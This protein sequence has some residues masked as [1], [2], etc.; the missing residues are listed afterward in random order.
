M[1]KGLQKTFLQKMIYSQ[2][3]HKIGS[4]PLSTEEKKNQTMRQHFFLFRMAVIKT[5]E[6]E[7]F[8]NERENLV[9]VE[10]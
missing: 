2:L 6:K 8:S 7:M 9:L 5:S 3:A 4:T 10:I 1:N